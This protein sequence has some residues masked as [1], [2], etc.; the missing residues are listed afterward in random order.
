MTMVRYYTLTGS[1][2]LLTLYA[3]AGRHET[4]LRL[5]DGWASTTQGVAQSV[6]R[7]SG[8]GGHDIA[9][10]D[11]DYGVRT[12]TADYRLMADSRSRLLALRRQTRSLAGRLLRVRVT[13][14]MDDLYAVGRL[15]EVTADT[16]AANERTQTGSIIV[17]C[18]RPEILS[19]TAHSA[20]LTAARIQPG[21]LAY[22]P[23]G[24][25][26]AYPVNYGATGDGNDIGML[27][28]GGSYESY[29]LLAVTGPFPDGLLISHDAGALEY[30]APIPSS[31]TLILDCDPRSQSATMGGVDVGRNLTRRDLP[32]I[33]AG[34]SIMLRLLSAGSGWVT[35][36]SRDTYL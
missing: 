13:D 17:I 18:D 31:S 1:T 11:L 22:G 12:V 14:D 5:L 16:G 24:A 32:T 19:W 9:E 35:C 30:A 26:L 27:S 7:E 2:P 8:N 34:G 29:P 36:T 10:G 15:Q 6:E 25:G 33:P 28:N 21:G 20:Q 23:S 4:I 3:D